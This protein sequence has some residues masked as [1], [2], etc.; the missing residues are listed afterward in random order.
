MADNMMNLRRR[1]GGAMKSLYALDVVAI[2]L[3]NI[4]AIT[5][6]RFCGVHVMF[7]DKIGGTL[8]AS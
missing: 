4:G 7:A 5:W 1:E 3:V 6:G 2:V 8:F